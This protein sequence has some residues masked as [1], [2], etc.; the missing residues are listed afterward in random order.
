[1]ETGQPQS[2]V[3]DPQHLLQEIDSINSDIIL[4]EESYDRVSRTATEFKQTLTGLNA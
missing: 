3:R 4:R 1:L 2:F